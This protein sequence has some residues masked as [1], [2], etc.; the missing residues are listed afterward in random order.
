MIFKNNDIKKINLEKNKIILFYGQN[1]GLKNETINILLNNSNNVSIYDEKEIL[2][3][4][5]NFSRRFIFKIT[6]RYKQKNYN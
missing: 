3:R 6:I 5:E 1:E 2:D 4:T